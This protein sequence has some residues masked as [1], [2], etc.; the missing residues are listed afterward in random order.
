MGKKLLIKAPSRLHFGIVNPFSNNYRLYVSSGVAISQPSTTVEI[1]VDGD[2]CFEGCRS[3]EVQAKLGWFL[4]K[5]EVEKGSVKIIEC[6][7]KHVG[8]G[9]TTQL[10]L[11]VAKGLAIA[12]DIEIDIETLARELGRGNIS[13][14][15]TYVF[16]YGGFVVDAG[17]KGPED[18]PK[19]LLRL[20]FPEEWRFIVIIPPGKG[21]SEKEEREVF[22]QRHPVKEELIWKASHYLFHELIPA[23]LDRDF[24]AFARAL[25]VLQETIGIMFSELQGGIYAGYSQYAVKILRKH[26]IEGVGQSSWGPSVYGVVESEDQAIKVLNEI[27]KEIEGKVFIARPQNH[28]AVFNLN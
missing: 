17:K 10:L 9:S 7:D 25:G 26:G 3:D 8:L 4:R 23:L 2:L 20:E 16:T 19:L 13:G 15:G 24:H 28:G 11:S 6:V 27:R 12:N 5:Y 18:F 22:T 1:H 21:L 14:V